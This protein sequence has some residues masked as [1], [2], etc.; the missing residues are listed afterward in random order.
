MATTLATLLAL[1]AAAA[2][3][4]AVRADI[5]RRR[6]AADIAAR[7]A[8]EERLE[9]ILELSPIAIAIIRTDGGVER[10]NRYFRELFGYQ[11]GEM[12]SIEQWW[13]RAYPDADYRQQAVQLSLEMVESSRRSGH[14]SGPRE[15]HVCCADGSFKDIEFH[16]VDL[17]ESGVWTMSDVSQHYHN[18]EVARRANEHLLAQLEENR[19]LQDAL[20]EQATR[21]PLT[22]LVNRRYLDETLDRELSRAMREGYPLAVMMIDIDF[23]KRLNDTYGHLAGDEVL[24]SLATLLSHGARAEDIIC[25]FGGEEFAIVLPKMPIFIAHERAEAWRSSFE[26]TPITF[27]EFELRST[28]SAGIA[29]FPGNGRN[30]DQLIDA[31]DAA[32]YRAKHAGRNRV[33]VAEASLVVQ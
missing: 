9:R 22:G 16:Y 29:M 15:L 4:Y 18:E 27:G 33:E 28:L 12:V 26:N 17:G 31:A 30:R 1:I 21:D 2:L 24:R 32:L 10:L 25:R 14:A 19:R 3:L 8:R 7:Q 6:L 13:P 11:A 20:R 23:F 5:M